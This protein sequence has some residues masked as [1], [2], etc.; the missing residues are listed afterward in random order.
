MPISKK[1]RLIRNLMLGIGAGLGS[2]L[3]VGL[4]VVTVGI[5]KFGWQ[6]SVAGFT[7]HALPYPVAIVNG[8]MIRYSNYV[9]DLATV[10]RY[11][12]KQQT[13]IQPAPTDEQMRTGVLDRLI[14][15]EVL[16]QEAARYHVTVTDTEVQTEFVKLT[17]QGGDPTAQIADLYGWTPAQF[18]EK[19]MRPYLLEQKLAD[20]LAK[21]SALDAATVAKAKDVL[22]K[23]NAGGDFADLAKQYSDD[24]GSAAKGGDLGW[25]AKGVMVPEFEAVAFALKPGA[26]SDLVKTQFG[27]HIIKVEDVQKDKK[28]AV[29]KVKASH[30]LIAGPS[31]QQYLDGKVKDAKVT[32]FISF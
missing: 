10:R 22:A 26:V 8:T 3:L 28:D 23:V 32:K 30:I 7:M 19:V 29:I 31:V 12:S 4:G 17:A 13:A 27:Y 21:D 25:F 6:N 11:F 15:T 18:Q 5:Y 20:A 1:N 24:P 9:D 14:Q 16:R 2:I